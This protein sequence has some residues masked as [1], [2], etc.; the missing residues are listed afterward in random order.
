MRAH[1]VDLAVNVAC[2][3]IRSIL[4]ESMVDAESTVSTKQQT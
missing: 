3:Y 4:K 2:T 1:T